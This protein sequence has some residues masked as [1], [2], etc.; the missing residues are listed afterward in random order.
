[1]KILAFDTSTK[2]LS[3][4]CL[5]D[6]SVKAAFHE[7]VGIRH[8]EILIPTIKE[9]VE[10]LNW[11]LAEVELLC[12]GLGPGS[13]TGLRIAIAT[14]KGL[15][16]VLHNKVAGV[17]TMDAIVA[18]LPSAIAEGCPG[19]RANLRRLAPFLDARKGKIYTCIYDRSGGEPQRIT[20]YLLV[21][22][23]ELLD[24]LKEEVF[25]FGDAVAKYKKKL[26]FCPLALYAEDIDWYPRAVEIGR[27]GFRRSLRTADDPETIDP[28]YLHAKECNIITGTDAKQGKV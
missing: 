3:I 27:I 9:T 13:F 23:D 25:F 5:E 19:K 2:F 1:M 18:G 11:P 20:D 24:N 28:L 16:A 8:S 10:R 12:V 15:A 4:A 17:P 26:D 21:T 14:V 22:V 6:D 7:D